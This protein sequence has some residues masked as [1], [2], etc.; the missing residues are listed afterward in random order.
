[1]R[2]GERSVGR[3]KSRIGARD[4]R[5]WCR[6]CWSGAWSRVV[7]NPHSMR[8]CGYQLR[9]GVGQGGVWVDV[10]DWEG[11][12][13][14]IHAAGGKNDGDEVYA[15]IFEKRCGAGFGEELSQVKCQQRRGLIR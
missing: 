15:G 6:R 3:G 9:D 8:S 14:V 4:R 12:L 1:M 11:V 10:K 2:G 13:A 7:D 5:A